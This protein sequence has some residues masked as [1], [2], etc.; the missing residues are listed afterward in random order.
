MAQVDQGLMAGKTVL[1]TGATSRHR[2][3]HRPGPGHDG[4]TPGDHWP[5]RQAHRGLRPGDPRSRRWAGRLVRRRLVLPVRGSA[6]G[7][8]GTPD[9]FADRC[10]DQQRRRVLGHPARH[11]DGLERTFAVNHLAPFLLTNLLLDRL[12][13]SAP[14]RVV[15]VSSNAHAHRAHRLRR[16]PGRAVLLRGTGLQPV[17]ARQRR[18]SATSWPGGF[19]TRPSP[20]TRCIPGW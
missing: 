14:A 1:I 15:T 5:R 7:R 2:Q 13:Q 9:P 11:R 19:R 12:K 20:P 4:C 6:A 10:A 17:Q 8:G 18:C 3:G 16:S